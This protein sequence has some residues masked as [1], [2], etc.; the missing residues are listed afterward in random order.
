MA[1]ADLVVP[2]SPAIVLTVALPSCMAMPRAA[3]I[4]VGAA[5]NARECAESD[6]SSRRV[7]S[8]SSG[9]PP[10]TPWRYASK[11]VGVGVGIHFF[12][13]TVES[14]FAIAKSLKYSHAV[15]EKGGTFS[16]G[17]RKKGLPHESGWVS[18]RV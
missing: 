5:S 2:L 8:S 1:V 15:I 13:G 16:H 11:L 9:P 6:R 12:P 7:L 17:G 4:G 10:P 3:N 18:L 14:F